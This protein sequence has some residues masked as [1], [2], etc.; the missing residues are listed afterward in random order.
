MI[1]AVCATAFELLLLAAHAG[2]SIMVTDGD[3]LDWWFVRQLGT[4]RDDLA[5]DVGNPVLLTSENA[6]ELLSI[7]PWADSSYTTYQ[8][9]FD[10]VETGVFYEQ[11]G[12]VSF[13]QFVH[14]LAVFKNESP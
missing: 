11:R 7:Y 6:P 13:D 3:D 8:D 4:T 1:N 12:Q 9:H 14:V 10:L 5:H 2:S